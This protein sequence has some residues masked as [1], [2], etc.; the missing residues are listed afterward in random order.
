MDSPTRQLVEHLL[1]DH[2][3]REIRQQAVGHWSAEVDGQLTSVHVDSSVLRS[4]AC[5]CSTFSRQH[6][7]SHILALAWTIRQMLAPKPVGTGKHVPEH[8]RVEDALRLAPPDELKAF[9]LQFA[10]RHPIFAAALRT[11]FA[12]LVQMPDNRLKYLHLLTEQLHSARRHN[13][14]FHLPT[15]RS[16]LQSVHTLLGAAQDALVLQDFRESWAILSALTETLL[17][18]LRKL[19]ARTDHR[20]DPVI[21]RAFGLVSELAALSAPPPQ[22]K[23]EM[24]V[25]LLALTGKPAIALNGLVLPLL[26]CQASF[27]AD[28]V[29]LKDW[30]QA[31]RSELARPNLPEDHHLAL[32]LHYFLLSDPLKADKT[33]PVW[34]EF[35][36]SPS[37]LEALI[38]GAA[39]Y[40]KTAAIRPILQEAVHT[41]EL[42][43]IR[44]PILTSLFEQS[45]ARA[46]RDD[47][48]RW[49]GEL[50]R[51][52]ID[53]RWLETARDILGEKWEPLV[54]E[55]L[56][57][58][59]ASP[60][61]GQ[62]QDTIA[63]LMVLS[64]RHEQLLLFL[65]GTG[66][67]E[68]LMRYDP[69]L[70]GSRPEQLL[71]IYTDYFRDYLTNHLGPQPGK[72]IQSVLDH[73]REIGAGQLAAE[74][75]DALREAFPNR[76][77]LPVDGADASPPP[78]VK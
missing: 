25:Y 63:R 33:S 77:I 67:L 49:A 40:E 4:A 42:A 3:V 1:Q 6:R 12:P 41:P 38:R 35:L 15:L 22:L 47:V 20:F 58:Y 37:A 9:L 66:D 21:R 24:W 34:Q 14:K 13:D 69:Y 11:R 2:A 52:T 32:R 30:Q 19:N 26:E 65:S 44:L 60:R 70:V 46:S 72:K 56:D 36:Q 64:G 10:R 39:L 54:N 74:L 7:C 68:F 45:L 73:F 18:V 48:F 76:Q 29:C 78:Y 55:L 5:S 28:P 8:I 61:A 31:V 50:F 23:E 51:E 43:T 62:R 27:L 71:A 17:P 53:F 75:M 16:F 59:L 57:E